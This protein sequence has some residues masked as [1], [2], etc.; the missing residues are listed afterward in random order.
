LN[1]VTGDVRFHVDL[2]V[3]A[4]KGTRHDELVVHVF[5]VEFG[6]GAIVVS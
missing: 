6:L 5:P 2:D 3:L 1:E 4:T